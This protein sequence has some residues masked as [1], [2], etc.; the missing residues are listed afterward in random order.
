MRLGEGKV[1]PPISEQELC[2]SDTEVG[3]TAEMTAL[4]P[5]LSAVGSSETGRMA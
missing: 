5:L 1:A 2:L 4:L 3:T